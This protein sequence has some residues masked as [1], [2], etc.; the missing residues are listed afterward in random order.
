ML[1]SHEDAFYR[2]GGSQRPYTN[3]LYGEPGAQLDRPALNGPGTGVAESVTDAM[4]SSAAYEAQ[5]LTPFI[6]S[7]RHR[8]AD[9][10]LYA[11]ISTQM[12]SLHA[13]FK[14]LNE[15]DKAEIR[16][17]HDNLQ[18]KGL[19]V[20]QLSAENA[21]LVQRQA[22]AARS[23]REQV[24]AG[25][26]GADGPST[27]ARGATSGHAIPSSAAGRSAQPGKQFQQQQQQPRKATHVVFLPYHLHPSQNLWRFYAAWQYSWTTKRTLW[28]AFAWVLVFLLA[29][30]LL[31]GLLVP[32]G[33][34]HPTK[35]TATPQL[36]DA[37][38]Q[39][40]SLLLS[41]NR[42]ATIYFAVVPA[43]W[44]AQAAAGR[45]RQLLSM[46]LLALAGVERDDVRSLVGAQGSSGLAK[47][48]V[49]CGYAFLQKNSNYT[50]SVAHSTGQPECASMFGVLRNDSA[51]FPLPVSLPGRCL[52]CPMLQAA[53]SYVFLLFADG[54]RS[55]SVVQ[56]PFRT[57]G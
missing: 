27:K 18:Q 39:Q 6:D 14:R 42:A 33:N 3:P 31:V 49:A 47:Y 5:V 40:A 19:Q 35:F 12:S 28:L 26:Q 13:F 10:Q 21:G 36:V 16:R 38:A 30:A 29:V 50:L 45:R 8:Q 1:V 53:T 22:D 46:P 57:A 15:A 54:G 11:A 51:V 52:R 7:L 48:T 20:Q 41:V 4:Q 24:P 9:A 43:A 56:V 44:T 37:A 17:L 25:V 55:S 34:L 2:M 23:Q 32:W